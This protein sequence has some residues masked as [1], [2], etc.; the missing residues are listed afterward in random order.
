MM[1]APSDGGMVMADIMKVDLPHLGEEPDRHGNIRLYVRRY[2]RRIRIRVAR[3]DPGFVDAYQNA[4]VSLADLSR[5]SP[6]VPAKQIAARGSLG[7]LATLYF[8]SDEFKALASGSTRRAVI[9]EC[10]RETIRDASGDVMADCPLSFVTPAKIKRLRDLKKGLP[11]A[12]NN[13][14]KYLS[15]MFGWAVEEGHL[16]ANPARDVRRVKYATNGFHTWTVAEVAQFIER[17]PIGTKPYLALCLLLFIGARKSDMVTFGRQHTWRGLLRFVPKK[18]K[19]VR[20]DVSEKPIL[21]PL[22]AAIEAG[23]VGDLTFLVTQYSKPFTAK[24]FG[25]WFR[26]RCNEANLPHC[27]AHGLRKAGATILAE[28]GATTAQLMAIYDWS[29]AAQAEVYIRA[30]NRTRLAGQA[31]PL[32]V[33][34]TEQESSFVAPASPALSHRS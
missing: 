18:T 26:D 6:T 27:T 11:G 23:P 9:E 31:M 32:L 5:P 16:K 7:W 13:R 20:L 34:W 24:G 4:L 33:K 14:R 2:G 30:A 8:G 3:D 25:N 21:P 29:T 19:H 10:L 28:N 1:P 17:H 15:A 22:A 12:G